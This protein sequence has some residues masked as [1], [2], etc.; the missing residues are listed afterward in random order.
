MFSSL[1]KKYV[2]PML[3]NTRIHNELAE[4]PAGVPGTFPAATWAL[5]RKTP[6]GHLLP[7]TIAHRGY[8]SRYPEN[9]MGAFKGAVIEGTADAIETDIHTTKDNVL[10]LS[11]DGDLKR[12]FGRDERIVDCEWEFL[13]DLE[14]LKE[15]TQTMPSLRQLL[16][17]LAESENAWLL[18]DIKLDNDA[19][20]VMRLIAETLNSVKPNPERA[21]DKRVVL[22]V[23]AVSASSPEIP[24]SILSCYL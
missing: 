18:L 5:P 23:W 19:D 21:W 11:H 6:S 12:C 22:G 24:L 17:Y 15:P 8:K 7:Q 2:P 9:T 16:E 14:T 10:V 20:T 13:K 3:L 1:V 4:Y